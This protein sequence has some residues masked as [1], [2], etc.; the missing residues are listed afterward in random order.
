HVPLHTTKNYNGQ[1]T[2]QL[3][4]HAFWESR[5]PE[6]FADAQYDYFVGK[7][8]YIENPD[9]FFWNIVLSSNALVDSVLLIEKDL[10]KSFAEDQ[11]FCFDL[12]GDITIRTQCR[13]YAEAYHNRMKGMLESRM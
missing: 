13:A 11:Q 10:S 1:L 4:I 3:S 5:I 12:R 7:A 2:G 9:E 6:L 8:Q